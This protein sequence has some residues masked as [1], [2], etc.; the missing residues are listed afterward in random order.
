MTPRELF[1]AN[2]ATIE[3]VI[4]IVCRRGGLFAADAEDFASEARLALMENDYAILARY[5]RR[6]S[7]DTFLT[8]VVQR[9]LADSRT[10]AKGRWHASSEAQR[11]GPL[12]VQVETLV[13]RDG[14]TLDEAMPHILASHPGATREEVAALLERLPPRTG[15]P[16]PVDLESVGHVIAARESAD[17]RA[18]QHDQQRISNAAGSTMRGVLRGWPVADRMLI[19]LRFASE[20]SIADISR[21]MQLPQRPLYRR[22]ETLLAQ[23]RGA[24]TTAGIDA[25]TAEL[26]IGRDF[27]KELDFGLQNGKSDV[28]GQSM[29]P[30]EEL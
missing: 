24:L 13:R 30:R 9:L 7:L 17:T 15:R 12:A 26:L 20:M 23:L 21:V 3:R 2:L 27:E 18:M 29:Q 19:R 14:R 5:E 10:R 22:L 16:R 6:S 8:V 4:A 1:E 11:L 25:A 28:S